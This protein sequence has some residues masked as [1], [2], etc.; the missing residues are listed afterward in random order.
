MIRADVRRA[1]IGGLMTALILLLTV[2]L[3][4][5]IPATSG[6]IHLGD[7][8]IF[9]A[10]LLLG[11]FAA[12]C[13]GLGSAL[14]DL[15]GGYLIFIVPTFLIKGLMGYIAGRALTRQ[16]GLARRA[17]LFTLCE[18]VMAGGYFIFETLAFSPA[19][20]LS[21]LPMNLLQGAGGVLL[22]LAFC[23]IGD[24]LPINR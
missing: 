22:G 1:A 4:L 13:A 11:P 18:V 16:T 23:K 14:A 9:L 7:A 20:A 3:K 5:P 10:A 8:A 2:T 6:Y 12:L 17:I 21:S 19:A 15:L 24:A